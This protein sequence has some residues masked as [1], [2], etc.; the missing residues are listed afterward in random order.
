MSDD[1]GVLAFLRQQHEQNAIRR[2]PCWMSKTDAELVKARRH[3]NQLYR[4]V[5]WLSMMTLVL[6][7]ILVLWLILGGGA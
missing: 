4:R 3:V 5:L 7:V 6:N 1:S 2:L